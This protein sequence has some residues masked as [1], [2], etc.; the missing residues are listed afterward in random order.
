MAENETPVEQEKQVT[1]EKPAEPKKQ[2]SDK[3]RYIIMG[4][5]LAVCV[6]AIIL[7]CVFLID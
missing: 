5:A 6:V 4:V 3:T 1:Q 7:A 2:M